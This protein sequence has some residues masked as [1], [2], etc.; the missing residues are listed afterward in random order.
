MLDATRK[1]SEVMPES[2]GITGDK[3]SEAG[4]GSLR[5]AG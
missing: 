5:G 2:G 4:T 1:E 3:G